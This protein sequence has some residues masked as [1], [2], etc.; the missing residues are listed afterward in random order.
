MT[1]LKIFTNIHPYFRPYRIHISE[2]MWREKIF[3]SPEAIVMF[4][5]NPNKTICLSSDT[6]SLSAAY[7]NTSCH[8]AAKMKPLWC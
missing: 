1:R 8:G 3:L 7:L 4:Y 6:D 5:S 2:K